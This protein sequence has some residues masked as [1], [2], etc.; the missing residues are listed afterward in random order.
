MKLGWAGTTRGKWSIKHTEEPAEPVEEMAHIQHIVR[1][2]I[3]C[4]L[5][6]FSFFFLSLYSLLLFFPPLLFYMCILN[7]YQKA[8]DD[9]L[10]R[11]QRDAGLCVW[12]QPM[13]SPG[14]G[15]TRR[16]LDVQDSRR[17]DK[18]EKAVHVLR[19]KKEIPLWQLLFCSSQELSLGT[20]NWSH[21]CDCPA[22]H[23]HWAHHRPDF[24]ITTVIDEWLGSDGAKRYILPE[25]IFRCG[26][27]PSNSS[28]R[29]CF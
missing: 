5:D 18:R 6:S 16:A 21:F 25:A 24:S 7:I 14:K 26:W 8:P 2:Y 17:Y 13:D 1:P 29:F 19:M 4:F 23:G 3:L 22:G 20:A 28:N 11:V 15:R 27:R 9:N 10:I 12:H